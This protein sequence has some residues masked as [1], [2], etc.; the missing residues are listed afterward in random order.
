M[1]GLS[2]KLA[3]QRLELE[4]ANELPIKKSRNFLLI[5]KEI[6]LEPM[7]SLLLGCGVIYLLLGDRHE[8]I[9]LLGFLGLIVFITIYQEKKTE[10]ALEA[11]R[12][13]SSPRA[14]VMRDGQ[15]TR[16]AGREIVR[17]DL[18]ILMEGDRV[19]ADAKLLTTSHLMTDE[20]LLTGESV[21]LL[22]NVGDLVFAGTTVVRGQATAQVFAIGMQTEIGKIG[23][24]LEA[25]DP[26]TTRLEAET[27][28]LVNRLAF[29]AISLCALVVLVYGLTRHNWLEGFLTGLTLAMAILPNELPGRH[30]NSLRR[31]NRHPYHESDVGENAFSF[32][33]PR[34]RF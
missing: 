21:P 8:A 24:I 34:Q 33:K 2:P 30:H 28:K 16:I 31:Q 5:F 6:L 25:T 17:E 13:L 9:M 12:N 29:F 32:W 27:Q 3:R 7:V 14:L 11:L 15:K 20:S 19:P 18:L 23:K 10:N 4:G 26:Q 22:K 1:L